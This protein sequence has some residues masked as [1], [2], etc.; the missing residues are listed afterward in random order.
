MKDFLI[1]GPH[2]GGERGVGGC[3][4]DWV[5]WESHV[6]TTAPPR[7]SEGPLSCH[8]QALNAKDPLWFALMDRCRLKLLV[9]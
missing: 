7:T 1:D 2:S 6:C 5:L 8:P 4:P 3:R 9:T